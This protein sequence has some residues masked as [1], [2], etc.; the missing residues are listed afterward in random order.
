ME[1]HFCTSTYIYNQKNNKF[2]FIKHKKLKKWLMPGGHWEI[3]ELTDEA[4][5][6]EV[7][8]ET[9]LIV[10]LIGERFPRETDQVRPYGIQRNVIEEGRHEHLDLI[11]FAVCDDEKYIQNVRETDG[12]G[13]FTLQEINQETF[14]TF[15]HCRKW[16]NY[17]YIKINDLI[18]R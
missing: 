18:K 8:E 7:F 13:W 5:L 15:E 9:G 6:R 2:L 4:A 3:N 1:R 14:D 16:C 17:F 10:T 12:I 11:Y